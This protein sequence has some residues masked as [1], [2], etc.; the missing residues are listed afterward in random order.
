M[1]PMTPILDVDRCRTLLYKIGDIL[2]TENTNL[3][4]FSGLRRMCMKMRLRPLVN[5]LFRFHASGLLHFCRG[6]GVLDRPG[7]ATLCG[8]LDE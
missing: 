1:L 7:L 2:L 3:A 6:C 8:T 4:V 5:R